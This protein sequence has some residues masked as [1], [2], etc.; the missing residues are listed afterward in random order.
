MSRLTTF[1]VIRSDLVEL[2]Q[3]WELSVLAADEN[4][5]GVKLNSRRDVVEHL[6]FTLSICLM[7]LS[8]SDLMT[9]NFSITS[10]MSVCYLSL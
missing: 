7:V 1:E 8:H 10:V 4:G 5:D 2:F 9:T 6:C 3:L